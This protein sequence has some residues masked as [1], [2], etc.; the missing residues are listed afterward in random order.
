MTYALQDAARHHIASRFRAATDRDIS[1]L[2]ADECLRRGLVAPDG[3]PAARLCLGSH[4]AVSDL[5]FRRL[6]FGWEEVVYVYDG[7]RGEQAKYLKAK[8]D[9]TVALADSG[10]ELTPEVEQRLAQAV[11]ALEQLWQSWAG[12]QATTTDDL[13]RALDEAGTY[14]F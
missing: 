1:G 10:D 12:Y 2:A 4:S 14:G 7:T 5:L 9:L 3:T 13:A 11:A 6:R 8:L